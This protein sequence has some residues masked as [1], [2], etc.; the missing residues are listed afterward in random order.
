MIEVI[1][2][3][4]ICIILYNTFK[5]QSVFSVTAPIEHMKDVQYRV[6]DHIYM[7]NKIKK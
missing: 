5:K 1:V 2:A 7:M 6:N 3:L 4:I